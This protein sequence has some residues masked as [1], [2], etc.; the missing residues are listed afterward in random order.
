[1]ADLGV[2]LIVSGHPKAARDGDQL[3]LLRLQ[4]LRQDVSDYPGAFHMLEIQ[5][6]ADRKAQMPG[7]HI[8]VR[9]IGIV[10]GHRERRVAKLFLQRKGSPPLR[11]YR[12]LEVCLSLCG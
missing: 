4:D 9:H 2:C 6:I 11:R 8:G 7:T 1:M 10:A 5:P 3:S 12:T